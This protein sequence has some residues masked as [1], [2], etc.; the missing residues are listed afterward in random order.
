MTNTLVCSNPM[1][2]KEVRYESDAFQV[3]CPAC[4]TWHLAPEG[5][6]ETSSPEIEEDQM[7][8]PDISSPIAPP[9]MPPNDILPDLLETEHPQEEPDPIN[10]LPEPGFIVTASG[11]RFQ[12][13]MGKN[14]IG[15]K[16]PDISIQDKTIS[17][18]HCVIEVLEAENDR[19]EQFIYDI[20]FESGES[21]TNGVFLSGRSQRL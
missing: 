15:R 2:G 14:I 16:A 8:S 11:E 1:C 4:N 9:M 20:G 21:S 7:F 18:V 6:A 10:T 3:I 19:L 12:L 5:G 13:K 17:R